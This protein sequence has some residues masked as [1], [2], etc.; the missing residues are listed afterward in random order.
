MH[1]TPAGGHL[2]PRRGAEGPDLQFGSPPACQTRLAVVRRG[3]ADRASDAVAA[4]KKSDRTE[5]RDN[6][7]S[8][9]SAPALRRR[10]DQRNDRSI[11]ACAPSPDIHW[12]T[13]AAFL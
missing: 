2:P 4:P 8:A 11:H 5:N 10:P 12:G 9:P 3:W 1:S 6:A 7:G 13:L